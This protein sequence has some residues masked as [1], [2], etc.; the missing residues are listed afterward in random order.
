MGTVLC[1]ML[2]YSLLGVFCFF[3]PEL[4][5]VYSFFWGVCTCKL[6][7]I[8]SLDGVGKRERRR[9]REIVFHAKYCN[10]DMSEKGTCLCSLTVQYG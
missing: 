10:K 3:F 8:L 1:P 2:A 9:G 6:M 7:G 4:V 5:S